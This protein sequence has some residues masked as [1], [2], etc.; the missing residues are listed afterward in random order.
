MFNSLRSCQA[1][2]QGGCTFYIPTS[3]VWL[4]MDTSYFPLQSSPSI[5]PLPLLGFS[6]FSLVF[7]WREPHF[8]NFWL[9]SP[10]LAHPSLL[11]AL[12]FILSASGSLTSLVRI[13][14][15]WG[16]SKCC[17]WGFSLQ[18]T[19]WHCDVDPTLSDVQS[20]TL[21]W[22]DLYKV[23]TWEEVLEA[24]QLYTL[25]SSPMEGGSVSQYLTWPVASTC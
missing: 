4:L 18:L 3:R 13:S 19:P 20:L 16:W 23:Q 6:T 11:N 9:L 21:P 14:T 5:W 7:P 25:L 8:S 15:E 1:V 10:S 12:L 24:H 22:L 17:I 2:F